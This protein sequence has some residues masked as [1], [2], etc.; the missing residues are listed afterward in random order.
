VTVVF[1]PGRQQKKP[2]ELYL[3]SAGRLDRSDNL[4]LSGRAEVGLNT[5]EL[6]A[7]RAQTPTRLTEALNSGY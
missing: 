7:Y 2:L 1:S 5:G 3:T 4:I 6:D